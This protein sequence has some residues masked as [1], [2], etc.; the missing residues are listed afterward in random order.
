MT[1]RKATVGVEAVSVA[2]VRRLIMNATSACSAPGCRLCAWKVPLRG[3]LLGSL[4]RCRRVSPPQPER[5]AR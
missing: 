4:E 3:Q 2:A 1:K 5:K